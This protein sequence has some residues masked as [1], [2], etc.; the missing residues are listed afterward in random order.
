M[1]KLT[2]VFIA[3]AMIGSVISSPLNPE[4]IEVGKT[5][6]IGTDVVDVLTKRIDHDISGGM[7]LGE[8]SDMENDAA[9]ISIRRQFSNTVLSQSPVLKRRLIGISESPSVHETLMGGGYGGGTY[10]P[11]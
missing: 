8:T 11:F 3:V 5:P 7:E 10:G 6:S 2:V 4:G 9:E 1:F